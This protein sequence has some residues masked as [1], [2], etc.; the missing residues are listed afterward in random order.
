MKQLSD[1]L[2]LIPWH[3][4]FNL[5]NLVK[6]CPGGRLFDQSIL[7]ILAGKKHCSQ[8]LSALIGLSKI[9]KFVAL[10]LVLPHLH[11]ATFLPS[12]KLCII[13][14]APHILAY[15]IHSSIN[16]RDTVKYLIVPCMWHQEAS[17]DLICINKHVSIWINLPCKGRS[18]KE[19]QHLFFKNIIAVLKAKF[20]SELWINHV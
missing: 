17:W 12:A 8:G 11:T 9:L 13:Y 5:N 14:E 19:L 7:E 15:S 2:I 3:F 4:S 18:D 16:I 6:T 20:V 1:L 10:Y